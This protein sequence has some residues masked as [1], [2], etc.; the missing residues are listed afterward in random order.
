MRSRVIAGLITVADHRCS[1]STSPSRSRS[2]S[3]ARATTLSAVFENA[4]TL[5]PELAGADRRG[6]RR[7]GHLGRARGRHG[8]GHL[9]GRRRGAADPRRRDGRDPPA[10][11]PRG[12]LLPRPRPRQPERAGARRAATTLPVDP[13]RRSRCSSTRCSTALQAARAQEPP[14]P[15]DRGTGPRSRTSR[16]PPRTPTRTPTSR[17]RPRREALNDTF[18]YGGDAG[19]TSAIVNEALLGTEPHDLS[20]LIDRPGEIFG[21][22]LSREPQLKDLL[23]NFNVFTGA[24]A[25]ES[26]NLSETIRLLAPTLEEA[27][28]RSPTSTRASRSCARFAIEAVPGVLELPDTIAAGEPWL[29]ADRSAARPARAR[30]PRAAAAQV[31]PG[32]GAGDATRRPAS[33]SSSS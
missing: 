26:A 23:T 16:R 9:H 4:A 25:D 6:Q 22:L 17:A 5:T 3:P 2:R 28:R 8:Q 15:P 12:Q 13:D 24:L 30:R 27:S 10:A 31:D 7:Q 21:A 11:L 18:I 32:P 14:G 29:A 1:A 19:R 33:S 20:K